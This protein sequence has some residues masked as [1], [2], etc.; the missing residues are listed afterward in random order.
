MLAARNEGEDGQAQARDGFGSNV[1]VRT[2]VVTRCLF[3][4]DLTM[5]KLIRFKETAGETR[6]RV[7]F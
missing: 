3:G 4:R 5:T 6:C 2:K 7:Y 1:L